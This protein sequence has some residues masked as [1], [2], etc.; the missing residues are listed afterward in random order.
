[1][2]PF[3]SRSAAEGCST[4]ARFGSL[5]IQIACNGH[6]SGTADGE[7]G[8]TPRRLRA[9]VIGDFDRNGIRLVRVEP[10]GSLFRSLICEKT[11]DP[12]SFI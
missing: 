3:N 12:I 5:E 4:T 7:A 8:L 11:P 1:V 9:N 6:R 10:V 2:R